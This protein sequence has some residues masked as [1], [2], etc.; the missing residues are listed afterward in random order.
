MNLAVT[1]TK[2]SLIDYCMECG[3]SGHFLAV[4]VL[5][6]FWILWM[7]IGNPRL[8]HRLLSSAAML[9]ILIGVFG[10][11]ATY[12]EGIATSRNPPI[13]GI[14]CGLTTHWENG[15][16]PLIIG[17]FLT[18]VFNVVNLVFQFIHRRTLAGLDHRP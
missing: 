6:F 8:F 3:Q 14:A 15:L 17:S 16:T 9:P 18:I 4:A 7:A 2:K 1:V 11:A 13:S 10:S 12:Y 5:V